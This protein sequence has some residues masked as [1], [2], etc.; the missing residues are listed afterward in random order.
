M[1]IGLDVTAAVSQGG[2]I[3]RY[4]RELLRALTVLDTENEYSL[5]FASK[6]ISTEVL[7]ALPG[8]FRARRIPFHDIWLAR[9]W[10]RLRA[11]LPVELIT[12]QVAAWRGGDAT[13]LH[14][15]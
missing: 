4:V 6:D 14:L 10:H 13:D 2:G 15:G 9:V 5:F 3:G 12:G 11:P 1:R 7:P 8:N